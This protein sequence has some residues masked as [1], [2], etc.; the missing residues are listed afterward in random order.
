MIKLALVR[1]L[2]SGFKLTFY[3]TQKDFSDLEV[4]ERERSKYFMQTRKMQ[5]ESASSFEKE[6]KIVKLCGGGRQW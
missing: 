3:E 1:F 2:G 4:E 6:K 5:N